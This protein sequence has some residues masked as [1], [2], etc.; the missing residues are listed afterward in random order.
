MFFYIHKTTSSKPIWPTIPD[1]SPAI[2]KSISDCSEIWKAQSCSTIMTENV[3][4]KTSGTGFVFNIRPD[5]IC[6]SVEPQDH[7][8]AEKS[9][10]KL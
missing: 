7:R 4:Y 1:Q 6:Q 5:Y 2:S 3:Y 10:I 8:S 9:R